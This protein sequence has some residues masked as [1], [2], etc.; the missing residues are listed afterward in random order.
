[1]KKYILLLLSVSMLYACLND[2]DDRPNLSFD[3]VAIDE[4]TAPTSFTFGQKDTI[5]LTYSLK[6]GCTYFDNIYYEYEDTTRIVAIRAITDLDATCTDNVTQ[7][8][9]NLIVTA[10]QEEDYLF[11]MYKGTDTNGN[12]IFEE[13]IVP[14]N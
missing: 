6:N 3:F 1:M 9:Y 10:T 2:D 8:N 7:Y 12:S 13:L 4:Y 14:V 11:K 5:K